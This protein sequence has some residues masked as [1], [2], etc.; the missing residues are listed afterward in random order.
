MQKGACWNCRGRKEGS[1]SRVLCSC[2][3]LGQGDALGPATQTPFTAVTSWQKLRRGGGIPVFLYF[4][5]AATN[6]FTDKAPVQSN[7][8]PVCNAGV[9]KPMGNPG[10]IRCRVDAFWGGGFY[11]RIPRNFATHRKPCSHREK[12]IRNK[13]VCPLTFGA[14]PRS[15]YR[16]FNKVPVTTDPCP[17]LCSSGAQSPDRGPS[18]HSVRYSL[19]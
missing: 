16:P 1:T 4:F 5:V 15:P 3:D 10:R 2:Q 9:V 14:K 19:Y 17:P 11:T 12:H 18:L 7:S 8:S 13:L 6:V